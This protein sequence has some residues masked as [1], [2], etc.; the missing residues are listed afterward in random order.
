MADKKLTNQ[1]K[2]TLLLDWV[3]SPTNR[4]DVLYYRLADVSGTELRQTAFDR[5]LMITLTPVD[6]YVGK[7][8]FDRTLT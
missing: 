8:T 4:A 5:G 2:G 3:N 6:D 1:N 7:I